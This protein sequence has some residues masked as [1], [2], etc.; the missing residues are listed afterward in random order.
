MF[1]G[2]KV[3]VVVVDWWGSNLINSLKT[4]VSSF[5]L[6]FDVMVAKGVEMD[7]KCS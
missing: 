5:F 7:S 2:C 4:K 1:Y 3:V 6:S